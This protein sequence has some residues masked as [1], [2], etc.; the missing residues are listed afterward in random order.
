MSD[1]VL[2]GNIKTKLEN[3]LGNDSSNKLYLFSLFIILIFYNITSTTFDINSVKF[4]PLIC[5]AIRY[6]FLFI[7]ALKALF[8][9]DYTLKELIIISLIGCMLLISAYIS[10]ENALLFSFILIIGAKNCNLKRIAKVYFYTY[11]GIVALVFILYFLGILTEFGMY[12]GDSARFAMGFNHPNLLGRLILVI[13][14]SAVLLFKDKLRKVHYIAFV[15]A[16]LFVWFVPQCR[17]VF[18][19]MIVLAILSL[20]NHFKLM[21]NKAIQNIIIS[22]VPIITI[23]CLICAA[24]YNPDSKI[25]I[26]IDNFSSGRIYF[27]NLCYEMF[28]YTSLF[29]QNVIPFLDDTALIIDNCY[30]RLICEFGIVAL[31]MFCHINSAATKKAFDNKRFDI[32]I[33]LAVMGIF[34]IFELHSYV[35]VYNISLLALTA[36]ID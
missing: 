1:K 20:A 16:M 10:K 6:L 30:I 24:L 4:L 5:S 17:S 26:L 14:I 35:A 19:C 21:Q 18:L 29:G 32:A 22:A 9:S 27:S 2:F 12:R 25:W 7:I 28:G 3:K 36:E 34:G 23:V 33:I 8:L 13:I 15:L 31:Y 11:I